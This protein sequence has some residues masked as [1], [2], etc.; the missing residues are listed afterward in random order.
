MSINEIIIIIILF[1]SVSFFCEL[2]DGF[3]RIYFPTFSVLGKMRL[4]KA[5]FFGTKNYVFCVL[6]VDLKSPP[7]PAVER[8]M[9]F[10]VYFQ[11]VCVVLW[12]FSLL[13]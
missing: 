11:I 3:L 6:V 13:S 2:T 12:I 5:A 8:G 10:Q 1:A 7:V 9:S 4:G